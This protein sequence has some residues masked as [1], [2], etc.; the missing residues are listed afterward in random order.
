MPD[1]ITQPILCPILIGR[2]AHIA[3]LARLLDQAQT[4]QGQVALI[5]GEAGIGKS[6]L[7]GEV[8][9]LALAQGYTVLQG[10]CFE[11]DRTL[12]YAPFLDLLQP[13]RHSTPQAA[14]LTALL[15]GQQTQAADH[16]EQT[17]RLLFTALADFLLDWPHSQRTT[18]HPQL[19][20]LEDLHWCDESSLE[21]LL[22]WL[23]HLPTAP[24]LLLVT[25]RS[26]EPHPALSHFLAEVERR[27]LGTDIELA[28]FQQDETVAAIR[29]IFG[30]QK[31]RAEFATALQVLTDGNP[32]FVEETLKSL[33][34]A[35]DIFQDRGV[36]TRKAMH[37]LRIPHS[38]QDAVQRRI[39]QLSAAA[40][41][42]ISIAAVA[43]QRFDFDLLQAVTGEP[44]RVLLVQIKELITAQLVMEGEP[45][46]FAFRHALTR[47]AIYG[48]LL[49][50]ERLRLHHGILNALE[51]R[52]AAGEKVLTELAYHA[53]AGQ[54]WAKSLR[55]NRQA[56]EQAQRAFAPRAAA[57]HFSRALTAFARLIDAPR[58][59]QYALLRLRAHCYETLG[60]FEAARADYEAALATAHELADPRAAWE[61]LFSLGFL[62]T[63]HNMAQAGAYLDQALAATRRMGDPAL[64]AVSLNRIGNWHLN[65]EQPSIALQNHNEALTILSALNDKAGVALTHDLLGITHIVSGDYPGSVPHHNQAI[66]LYRQL[67]NPMSLSSCL[68]T[69]AL[70]GGCYQGETSIFA[71]ASGEV[72]W[73]LGQEAIALARQIGW[74]FG[75]ANACGFLS[76]A[77][78]VRGEYTRAL[79]CAQ[80][81]MD[82]ALGIEAPVWE[83]VA[84]MAF[85]RI[86]HDCCDL[87]AA[88]MHLEEALRLA[89]GVGAQE[90]LNTAIGF[91]ATLLIQAGEL[92]QAQAMLN[93]SRL[94]HAPPVAAVGETG[95]QR[96]IRCAQ[97]ELMLE[98]GNG[99]GA[100]ALANALVASAPHTRE[101]RAIPRLWHLRGLALVRLK[102]FAEAE[103][104]FS[105]GIAAA[106]EQMLRPLLWRLQAALGTLHHTQRKYELAQSCFSA[107]RTTVEMLMADL[108]DAHLRA[109]LSHGFASL[110]TGTAATPLRAAKAA[111]DGLTTRE[112]EVAVL[113]AR[114]LSNRAIAEQFVV[115]ERTVEKHVENA[116]GK[117]G[118]TSRTQL[119][120]WATE[121][122]LTSTS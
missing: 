69:A 81:A 29:A 52:A 49:G 77:M 94:L 68:G 85:G 92:A 83:G 43:G 53:H 18:Q 14:D 82:L 121:R 42:L 22:H 62:W 28:R 103:A 4:G 64:L 61:N 119:A 75:E 87:P 74:G 3:T 51:S 57:E 89:R 46:H 32:F 111:F 24:I 96:L 1:P 7:A 79:V 15:S 95:S 76:L 93:E 30:Q 101:G 65:M 12:P 72:C 107:A 11:P 67:D 86:H 50:R 21:F 84:H 117:L 99:L 20:L 45:D 47:Q 6:R 113:V 91:L 122:G 63:A 27:R 60:E 25:Y 116:S 39:A 13:L 17:K 71:A 56:G 54:Q 110:L 33:V 80:D 10:G 70:R 44:E 102:R 78:G 16:A 98:Q 48:G 109:S 41:T 106:Q 23:R 5:S 73:Q 114:G 8:K 37:E 120:V 9:Q 100:L 66:A 108:P 105:A 59:E 115:S 58:Q 34:T 36:W 40:N 55:H 118:F 104:T 2:D 26:D 90:F 31:V 112:R 97:A 38:V 35:G 88:Q 19:I